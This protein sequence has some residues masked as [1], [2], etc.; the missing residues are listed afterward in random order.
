MASTTCLIAVLA[1]R[2]SSTEP[3]PTS[4]SSGQDIK[5]L[6]R[7]QHLPEDYGPQHGLAGSKTSL[8]KHAQWPRFKGC[9]SRSLPREQKHGN[10]WET[11]KILQY[12]NLL[13]MSDV[14]AKTGQVAPHGS[15]SNGNLEMD[16]MWTKCGRNVKILKWKDWTLMTLRQQLNMQV[17]RLRCL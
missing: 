4:A 12:Q 17:C 5:S 6:T 13:D 15:K 9:S 10:R 8:P 2:P 1:T 16:E 14:K 11:Y 3:M 7:L